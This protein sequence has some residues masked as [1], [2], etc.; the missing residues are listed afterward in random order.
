MALQCKCCHIG[1]DHQ[2][3]R[4]RAVRGTDGKLF[5]V[6]ELVVLTM[7][8]HVFLPSPPPVNKPLHFSKTHHFPLSRQ[9]LTVLVR[10]GY[11]CL[12]SNI[13]ISR[14]N[15]C[16]KLQTVSPASCLAYLGIIVLI[17]EGVPNKTE[18]LSCFSPARNFVMFSR[19]CPLKAQLPNFENKSSNVKV[20]PFVLAQSLGHCLSPSISHCMKLCVTRVF[21]QDIR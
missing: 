11:R 14:P 8:K 2:L 19:I 1:H 15:E 7:A 4:G 20:M 18:I 17:V 6:T 3:R 12:Y 9:F 21:L 16:S 13:I 5:G 10:A